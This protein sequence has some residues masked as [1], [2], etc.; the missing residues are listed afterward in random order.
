MGEGVCEFPGCARQVSVL[1]GH[2]VFENSRCRP[3][4][5]G[6]SHASCE[7]HAPDVAAGAY[8]GRLVPNASSPE[9]LAVFD[10]KVSPSKI[11]IYRIGGQQK[12]PVQHRVSE[13]LKMSM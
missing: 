10:G 2:W 13:K 12:T 9:T 1:I 3:F 8:K 4:R 6:E 5:L 11:M 7:E